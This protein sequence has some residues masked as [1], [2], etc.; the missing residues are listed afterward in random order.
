MSTIASP[1]MTR[2]RRPRPRAAST[3]G[4]VRTNLTL[5]RRWPLVWMLAGLDLLFIFLAWIVL[6][7]TATNHPSGFLPGHLLS[8]SHGLL[9]EM[10]QMMT[11]GRR[12]GE[13]VAVAL[14]GAAFGTDFSS[15]VIRIN[16]SRGPTR[17]QYLIA[18]YLALLATS[19]CIVSI[20]LIESALLAG[21]IPALN[22]N[23]PTLAHFNGSV[24][25][26]ALTIGLGSLENM[27]ACIVIGASL[28]IVGRSTA[29][30]VAG[31]LV[32]L[33]GEDF[34]AHVL[35]IV[36]HEVHSP[37]WTTLVSYLYTPNLNA[38]FNHALPPAMAREMDLLDG[39]LPVPLPSVDMALAVAGI[40]TLILLGVSSWLF[41]ERDVTQ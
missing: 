4:L 23:A 8:G 38:L 27:V 37:T 10:G 26:G 7:Y 30:G 17:L 19:V 25:I 1:E 15:G 41:I 18:R 34:G 39:V 22:A 33:V 21:L 32:Y 35:P 3:A 13:F 40:Y 2:T 20:G 11:M 24:L 9:N 12:V 29:V 36:S 14:A 16:L 5:F 31:G 6:V 28:A